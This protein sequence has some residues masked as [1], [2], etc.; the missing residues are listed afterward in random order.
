MCKNCSFDIGYSTPI[1]AYALLKTPDYQVQV[2]KMFSK[3][4]IGFILHAKAQ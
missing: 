1:H 3:S 4:L 2:I